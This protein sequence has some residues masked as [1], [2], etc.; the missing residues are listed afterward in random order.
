SPGFPP[1]RPAIPRTKP[2][3]TDASPTAW[4]G[5]EPPYFSLSRRLAL[6]SLLV[7]GPQLSTPSQ[8]LPPPSPGLA[9]TL[10]DR[11]LP[12]TY[13]T[14]HHTYRPSPPLPLSP[15]PSNPPASAIEPCPPIRIRSR[16]ATPSAEAKRAAS[17]SPPPPPP[18]SA[19]RRWCWIGV[20][21]HLDLFL[22]LLVSRPSLPSL[23]GF[24]SL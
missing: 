19:L 12:S 16:R 3:R 15:A 6:S 13:H 24:V 20:E 11:R 9:R 10:L 23:S 1:G 7:P 2:V 18:P 4:T 14:Y 22:L 17:G 21:I 8:L 5:T